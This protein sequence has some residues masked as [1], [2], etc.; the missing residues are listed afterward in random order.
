MAD[1]ENYSS[2][3]YKQADDLNKMFFLL[4]KELVTTFPESKLNPNITSSNETDTNKE[5]YDDN[6]REMMKLQNEF[7]LLKNEVMRMSEDN[8]EEIN[9]L[10][11]KVEEVDNLNKKLKTRLDELKSSSYSAEGLFDDAQISRNELL[12]GNI[13]LFLVIL[14]GGI[15]AYKSIKQA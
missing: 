2:M 7:F 15:R 14:V 11:E 12:Y 9:Y 13:F 3:F 6:M 1:E 5:L 4:L 10:D 8:K